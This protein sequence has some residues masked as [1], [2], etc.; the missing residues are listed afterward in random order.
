MRDMAA[1]ANELNDLYDEKFRTGYRGRLGGYEIARSAA[2]GHFIDRVA[3]CKDA[4]SVLDYGCG[5]G[6]Y[7]PVWRK[8][9]H[10][11][12]VSFCDV[13]GEA[14]E[15]L[16]A[17]FPETRERQGRVRD[18]KAPFP[19]ASFDVIVSVEVMEHVG[20][21]DAYLS[22]IARLLRPGG[23]FVWTA[24]CANRF[25]LEHLFAVMTGNIKSTD[26]GFR[27]WRWEDPTHLRRLTSHEISGR[28][29]RHGLK[30][31]CFRFRAHLFSFLCTKL[32]P[33]R[34]SRFGEK[35]MLLD[36]LL[37][38]RLANGASMLGA[39]IKANEKAP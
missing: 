17:R 22:D 27:L 7:I 38:R 35:L 1:Q 5:G 25:S 3:G 11:A 34:F 31:P 29:L 14:L 10:D 21:L 8:V 9:F 33:N 18:G 12:E 36:Y 30:K 15:Q 28:L 2:L 4:M 39:A 26:E 19:D 23:M 20:D 16:S 32:I 13:S 6:L 37:F 24:P